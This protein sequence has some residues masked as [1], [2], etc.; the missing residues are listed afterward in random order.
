MRIERTS[1]MLL[2]ADAR[3]HRNARV[4]GRARVYAA[5]RRSA[6]RRGTL[7]DSRPKAVRPISSAGRQKTRTSALPAEHDR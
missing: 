3:S 2:G 1:H 7:L 6:L 5:V 4:V